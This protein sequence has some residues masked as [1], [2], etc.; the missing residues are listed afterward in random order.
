MKITF[1]RKKEIDIM[2][3]KQRILSMF[4]LTTL[5]LNSFTIYAN[6]EPIED[7]K[8]VLVE[9][10][11]TTEEGN[12]KKGNDFNV[13]F[14][15]DFIKTVDLVITDLDEKTLEPIKNHEVSLINEKG[16]I[17]FTGYTDEN[18]QVL[19]KNLPEGKYKYRNT[20][21]SGEYNINDKEFD[22]EITK[23][24]EVKGDTIF[25]NN[26]ETFLP[27]QIPWPRT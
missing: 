16:E 19:I 2:K 24:G 20:K 25:L 8:E 9:N 12:T 17:I 7:Q 26:K 3:I 18:G 6:A 1:F 21:V 22:I 5:F 27:L 13:D 10:N 15:D 23:K 14:D 4:L 11:N